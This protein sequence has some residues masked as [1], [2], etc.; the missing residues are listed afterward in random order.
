M[1]S[2]LF[3]NIFTELD[4]SP[5]RAWQEVKTTRLLEYVS[6]PLLVFE[7]I[8]PQLLPKIWQEDKY[9]VQ[10]KLLNILSFGKQWID[11]SIFNTAADRQ[12]YQLRDNGRGDR[13]RK[14]DHL[15][16]I[17]TTPEGKTKYTDRLEIDAGILTPLVWLYAYIF[18]RH[19]QKRW[20]KLVK[21]NFDYNK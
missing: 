5:E 8:E 3:L 9:L 10:V 18:F 14:W 13:V 1:A 15:I 2:G 4:C 17:E 12:V 19:R 21:N 7:P 20:H 11:I 16:V 6:R